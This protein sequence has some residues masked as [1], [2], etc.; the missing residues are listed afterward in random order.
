MSKLK[1]LELELPDQNKKEKQHS[2]QEIPLLINGNILLD[3]GQG[4]KI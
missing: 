1:G 2:F 4:G 3:L